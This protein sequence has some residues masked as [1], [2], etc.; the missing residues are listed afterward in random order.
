MPK[1]AFILSG[2]LKLPYLKCLFKKIRCARSQ[3]SKQLII[4]VSLKSLLPSSSAKSVNLDSLWAVKKKK[5]VI[6]LY[7]AVMKRAVI[8]LFPSGCL[9]KLYCNYCCSRFYYEKAILDLWTYWA[10]LP[11]HWNHLRSSV[12]L[13]CQSTSFNA[14]SADNSCVHWSKKIIII[15]NF[16]PKVVRCLSDRLRDLIHTDNYWQIR[17]RATIFPRAVFILLC[18]AE[19]PLNCGIWHSG[20]VSACEIC[21]YQRFIWNPELHFEYILIGFV[22]SHPF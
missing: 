7:L 6:L 16:D 17:M 2:H 9:L 10:F 20:L 1:A 12:T 21:G 8:F 19:E 11:R 15:K 13:R 22:Y 5:K 4:R 3:K 14:N 18:D